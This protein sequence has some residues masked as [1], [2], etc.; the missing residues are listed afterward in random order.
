MTKKN[1]TKFDP[2]MKKT[3][4]L[5]NLTKSSELYILMKSVEDSKP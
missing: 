1:M 5:S 4:N 2:G 3:E